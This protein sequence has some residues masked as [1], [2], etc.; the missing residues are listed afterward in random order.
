MPGKWAVSHLVVKV[1]LGT[2]SD[3]AAMETVHYLLLCHSLY[4]QHRKRCVQH[5]NVN[6]GAVV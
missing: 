6:C 5:R 3:A 2:Q 4:F 1:N